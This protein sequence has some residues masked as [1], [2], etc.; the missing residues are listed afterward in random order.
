MTAEEAR[1]ILKLKYP[2]DYVVVQTELVAGPGK[3]Y[4][5][6]LIGVYCSSKGWS[7]VGAQDTYEHAVDILFDKIIEKPK[8]EREYVEGEHGTEKP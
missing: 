1:E 4:D 8:L 6:T 2:E 3:R 5:R 7:Q